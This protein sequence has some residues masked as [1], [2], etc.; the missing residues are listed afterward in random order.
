MRRQ[1]RQRIAYRIS[2]RMHGSEGIRPCSQGSGRGRARGIRCSCPTRCSQQIMTTP[3][4]LLSR[5]RY[6]VEQRRTRPHKCIR[7][8]HCSG[9]FAAHRGLQNR[10]LASLASPWQQPAH[11]SLVR[12]TLAWLKFVLFDRLLC[13]VYSLLSRLPLV[14]RKRHPLTNDFPA[15]LVI[16]HLKTFDGL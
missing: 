4:G 1:S 6:E 12:V 13:K 11:H 9:Y 7:A 8:Y 16:F 5:G 2:A 14:L 3:G 10:S 15:R